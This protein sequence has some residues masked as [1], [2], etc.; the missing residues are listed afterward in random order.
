MPLK[1]HFK[2]ILL[3]V[4]LSG[5]LKVSTIT[6]VEIKVTTTLLFYVFNY[7]NPLYSSKGRL[8]LEIKFVA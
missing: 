2:I 7:Y 6:L 8:L 4:L 1:C 3:S 5:S